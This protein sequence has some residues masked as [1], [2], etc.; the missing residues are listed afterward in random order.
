MQEAN[1]HL[2]PDK[3]KHLTVHGVNQNEDGTYSWKFDNYVNGGHLLDLPWADVAEIWAAIACPVLLWLT[4]RG[5]QK[6]AP[7]AVARNYIERG[8][9]INTPSLR[10]TGRT[11]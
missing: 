7:A 10:I 6:R 2:S 11:R 8:T 3:A 9:A 5:A 1:P 4:E